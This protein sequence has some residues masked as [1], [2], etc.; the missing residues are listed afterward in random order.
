MA[1][2]SLKTKNSLFK[3]K[4]NFVSAKPSLKREKL[5]KLKL[6]LPNALSEEDVLLLI[7]PLKPK[8][9]KWKSSFVSQSKKLRPSSSRLYLSNPEFENSLNSFLNLSKSPANWIPT[10]KFFLTWYPANFQIPTP[11]L[12][13]LENNVS[14]AFKSS[15]LSLPKIQKVSLCP[16]FRS[17]GKLNGFVPTQNPFSF[18]QD[19]R[20][21]L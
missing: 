9:K 20:E 5:S 18:H 2:P 6:S 12:I 13:S 8:N 21:L 14:N 16:V 4:D 19:Q 17:N 7:S 3:S 10:F 1:K 11:G 15:F